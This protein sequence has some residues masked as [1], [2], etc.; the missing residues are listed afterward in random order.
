MSSFASFLIEKVIELRPFE[1]KDVEKIVDHYERLFITDRFKKMF[2]RLKPI[3]ANFKDSLDS[4]GNLFLGSIKY[5]DYRRNKEDVVGVWVSFDGDATDRG[6]VKIKEYDRDTGQVI[7][8]KIIIYYHNNQLT[9]KNIEFI[10]N[11]EL[12]HMKQGEKISSR[13]YSQGGLHYWL[14]PTE[15][16]NYTSNV[17]NIIFDV[18]KGKDSK[19][20][21]EIIR[22]LKSFVDGKIPDAIPSP[23]LKTGEFLEHVFSAKDD[24]RYRKEFLKFF[25]KMQ[26]AY[27]QVE[28]IS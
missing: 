17:V 3:E 21:E 18:I 1:K 16:N 15:V 12:I 20:K 10:I 14:D 24:P 5:H 23:L 7:E 25:K 11:H 4:D 22:F 28:N 13:K 26:W 19:Y 27:Q 9:R 2:Q 8:P 6:K